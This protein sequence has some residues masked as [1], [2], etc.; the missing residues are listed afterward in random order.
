[1]PRRAPYN[2]PSATCRLAY[3]C[4]LAAAGFAPQRLAL[5]IVAFPAVRSAAGDHVAHRAAERPAFA[6]VLGADVGSADGALHR[7]VHKGRRKGQDR[8]DWPGAR[9]APSRPV[10]SAAD[11]ATENEAE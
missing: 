2:A 9:P 11:R 7:P 8:A 3:L 5:D 6:A 10:G 4:V 1:M